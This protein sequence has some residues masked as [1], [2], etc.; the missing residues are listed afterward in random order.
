M[1]FKMPEL[2]VESILR[3]GFNNARRDNSAID[4][5]FADM[6]LPFASKKYGDKEINKIKDIIN[7][8][9]VSI[10]HAFNLTNTNFPCISIQLA[11][12]REKENEAQ[13]G[14]Y[15]DNLVLPFTTPTQLA[16][17]VIVAPFTPTSYDAVTGIVKVPDGVS[18]AAVYPNLLFV[19]VN[20]VEFPIIGGIDNDLGLK[21]FMIAKGGTPTISAGAQIKSSI[22]YDIYQH[23][24]NM[25]QTQLILG[26]HSKEAL[27]TKYLYILVKYFTLSRKTDMTSRGLQVNT[28]NGSDFNR[29]V[30]YAGDV[31]YSR[32]FHVSGRVQHEWRS[33][34]VQLVDNVQVNVK[35]PKDV[36]GNEA[37]GLT[38]STIQVEE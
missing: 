36:L 6:L 24:G 21:Q 2:I 18:L 26:I 10:V 31:V 14:D 29:N 32:F 13:W 7:N 38:D 35:V 16:S 27:L 30:E 20:G 28:Y 5:V 11:D 9:E 19:D 34:K 17:T 1:S 4:D 22:N 25:E 15:Q 12:D 3:D 23:R 37:L 33:D 8:D